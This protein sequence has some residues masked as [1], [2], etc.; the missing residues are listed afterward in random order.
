[1]WP[2]ERLIL[3]WEIAMY[4]SERIS[5]DDVLINQAHS[6]RLN[7]HFLLTNSYNLFTVQDLFLYGK[8]YNYAIGDVYTV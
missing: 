3:D 5:V 1:M 7:L 2:E 6:G 4:Y 8:L